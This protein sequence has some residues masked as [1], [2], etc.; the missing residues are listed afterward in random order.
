MLC[1]VSSVDESIR[2]LWNLVTERYVVLI[3]VTFCD[4]IYAG[5]V[6]DVFLSLHL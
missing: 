3:L 4:R 6:T 2:A 5:T 1:C